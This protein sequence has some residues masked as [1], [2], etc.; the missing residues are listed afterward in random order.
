MIGSLNLVLVTGPP[1]AGKSAVATP[2]ARQLGFTLM[3]K[4]AIKEALDDAVHPGTR[5]LEWSRVAGAATF[6]AMW[7]LAPYFSDLVLECNFRPLDP[8]QRERLIGLA[9]NPVEV[10]CRCPLEVA[11]TRYLTRAS[12]RHPVHVATTI[13]EEK[14]REFDRPLALGPVLEVDTT[15]AVDIPSLCVRVESY[16]RA[17]TAA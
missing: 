17:V 4:D 15:Q 2:L 1:G 8:G 12:S 11:R 10:Y 6:Q 5:D 7:A 9:P 3:A 14:L 13:S 16:L